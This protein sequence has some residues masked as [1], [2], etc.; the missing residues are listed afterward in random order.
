MP[1]SAIKPN[2]PAATARLHMAVTCC[3]LPAASAALA[4]GANA[5]FCYRKGHSLLML[6]AAKADFDLFSLLLKSGA[7]PSFLSAFGESAL[8]CALSSQD[9][10]SKVVYEMVKLLFQCASPSQRAILVDEKRCSILH[11]AINKHHGLKICKL[12]VKNGASVVATDAIGATLIHLLAGRNNAQSH[13]LLAFLIIRGAP[14]NVRL[15]NWR[16]G[17]DGASV[18][19]SALH[20]AISANNYQALAQLLKAGADP[21]L[22]NKVDQTALHWA[23]I[24]GTSEYINLL[25]AHGADPSLKDDFG[26]TAEQ[27]ALEY[28]NLEA[29]SFLRHH[30]E[31]IQLN[32]AVS[33]AKSS[34]AKLR[35]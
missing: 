14:L 4:N 31:S 34:N 5:S 21:N 24:N 7:D 35:I 6:A 8:S 26:R 10:S 2:S 1:S 25:L 27:C 19:G 12:L 13:A 28:N 20:G 3:D 33:K 9:A 17:N 16:L 23:A 30:R 18:Q 32:M 29:C 11:Y 22:D 15:C